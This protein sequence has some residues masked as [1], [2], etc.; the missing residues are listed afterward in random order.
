[1]ESNII[2]Y[3]ADFVANSEFATYAVLPLNSCFAVGKNDSYILT[4]SSSEVRV[5]LIKYLHSSTSTNYQRYIT[6]ISTGP[7][8][9]EQYSGSTCSMNKQIKNYNTNYDGYYGGGST[10]ALGDESR[11]YIPIND[12]I[13]S[14]GS[15]WD[16][17][18]YFTFG[19]R[20]SS[21]EPTIDYGDLNISYSTHI[22]ENGNASLNNGE[23][24]EIFDANG[25]TFPG[26]ETEI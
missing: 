2:R 11:Y 12:K 19:Q 16:N 3:K 6:T 10:S 24:I 1:M 9:L 25:G 4:S 13:S 5:V 17:A 15:N 20:A 8:T 7:Y 22:A 18:I 21:G 23:V 14:V 26:G